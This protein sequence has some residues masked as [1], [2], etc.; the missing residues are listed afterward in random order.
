MMG[1]FLIILTLLSALLIGGGIYYFQVYAYYKPVALDQN[2][3]VSGTPGVTSIRLTTLVDNL[4]QTIPV[5]DFQAIDADSSPLRFRGCFT[6]SLGLETLRETYVPYKDAVPLI[7]PGWFDCF[8]ARQIDA[9]L[10][11]GVA[12]A[13]L[14]EGNFKYGIDRI[15]AVYGDGRAFA[16]HQINSCGAVVFDGQPAPDG[17]PPTPERLQ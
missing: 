7:A 9:D 15:I 13:F 4:P 16:W 1:K 17:C 14:S 2:A 10:E 12:V 8:D 11:Q 6:T 3:T 5:S